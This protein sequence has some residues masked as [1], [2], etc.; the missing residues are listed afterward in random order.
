MKEVTFHLEV[1][2]GPLDLLLHLISKNKVEITDIPIALI[3]EQYLNYIRQMQEFDLDIA[4][5]FISMA[6]QLMYIKSKMLLPKHDGESEDDPRADLVQALLEYQ[7]FKE[8]GS[9]LSDR[10]ALGRD[11]YVR[12][13]EQL[14]RD[15]DR[16]CFEYTADALVKAV[17]DI[18]RRAEKALPPPVSAFQGIVGH[19]PVPVEEKLN[20]LIRLFVRHEVVDF[21][22]LVLSARS[23]SEVVAIFLAVLELSKSRKVLIEDTEDGYHLRLAPAEDTM[24]GTDANS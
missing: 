4:S 16:Y 1:F 11:L 23:R 2:D 5:D 6:A 12:M 20:D 14:E 9:L 21:Q 19:E 18:F 7:R 22:R 13:Q 3:C 10:E 8:A 15:P 17:E 24:E